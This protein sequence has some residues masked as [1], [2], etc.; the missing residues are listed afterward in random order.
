MDPARRKKS[1]FIRVMRREIK[2][3]QDGEYGMTRTREA[4]RF[5]EQLVLVRRVETRNRLVEQEDTCAVGR[6]NLRHRP[7]ES[8]ALPFAT[9]KPRAITCGKIG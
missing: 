6:G 7:G 5:A 1:H 9:G 2:I 4:A 8:D 3:M